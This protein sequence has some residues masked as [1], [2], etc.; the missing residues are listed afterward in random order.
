MYQ[1]S[2]RSA[3]M[4]LTG[5]ALTVFSGSRVYATGNG[6]PSGPH[7]NLNLIGVSQAKTQD[8]SGGSVIFVWENGTSK[9]YLAP[10]PFYVL[11]N[12]ATDANGGAFQLPAP[13]STGSFT[14]SVWLRPVGKPGGTGAITTC[15]TDPTTGE[16]VCSL[17]STVTV[18]NKGQSKFVNVSKSLLYITYVNSLG[19]TVTVPLFDASL[20]GYFWQYDNQGLKN[21][22]LRFY[23]QTSAATATSTKLLASPLRTSSM[24]TNTRK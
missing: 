5:I 11:D 1:R 23:Q 2:T 13:D 3:L 12:N 10:G 20:Q 14:Y 17:N 9:I 21:V 18:R 7:F 6:A 8:N 15:A 19:K 22:Q 4:V 24:R 16:V